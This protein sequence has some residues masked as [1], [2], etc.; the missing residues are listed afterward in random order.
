MASLSIPSLVNSLVNAAS[1]QNGDKQDDKF[2]QK[3]KKTAEDF[4]SV[5]LSQILNNMDEG[6]GQDPGLQEEGFSA[7]SAE[8]QW[9]SYKNEFLARNL[10]K[11]GGIGLSKDIYNS[12]LKAQGA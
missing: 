11:N 10:A 12:I 2:I 9:K 6:L 7:G 8:T 1:G 3:A 5:F 4:E